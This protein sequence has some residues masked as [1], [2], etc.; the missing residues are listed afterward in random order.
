MEED[1]EDGGGG[2]HGS[3]DNDIITPQSIIND[4][5]DRKTEKSEEDS[6]IPQ[7]RQRGH[8]K[9]PMI[10][11][12]VED[13]AAKGAEDG[14][15]NPNRREDAH[16]AVETSRQEQED[17]RAWTAEKQILRNE[18]TRFGVHEEQ[19]QNILETP[20]LNLNLLF[21]QHLGERVPPNPPR[22][23]EKDVGVSKRMI[24]SWCTLQGCVDFVPTP[25]YH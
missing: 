1:V 14:S 21:Q 10:E 2:G 13:K 6:R 8:D 18:M 3:D 9:S 23:A 17:F 22:D 25:C 20:N 11:V 24:R 4:S 19:I 15:T 12:M 5:T 16:K 7:A